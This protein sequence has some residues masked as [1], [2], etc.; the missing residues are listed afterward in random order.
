[1]RNSAQKGFTIRLNIN[2]GQ[3]VFEAL[4]E[5][6]FKYVFDLIGKLNNMANENAA[7]A[8]DERAPYTHRLSLQ[9][10]ELIVSALGEM[11]FSRVHGLVEN[12]NTQMREQISDRPQS[13]WYEEGPRKGPGPRSA[14]GR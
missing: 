3:I 13:W 7:D 11:P 2:Q 9:E 5:L 14:G 4:A 10:L 1:M 6:P 12:L 8:C